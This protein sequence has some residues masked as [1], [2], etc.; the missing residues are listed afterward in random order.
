MSSHKQKQQTP[1][2]LN[3]VDPPDQP[4]TGDDED[5]TS[6]SEGGGPRIGYTDSDEADSDRHQF[7]HPP[8]PKP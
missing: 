3:K 7:P 1:D 2:S 6:G 5:V 4:E 8:K